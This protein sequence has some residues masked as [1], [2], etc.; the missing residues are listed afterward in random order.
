[1]KV[2]LISTE[3]EIQDGTHCDE[4]GVWFEQDGVMVIV[5]ETLDE[6]SGRIV[7]NVKLFC[8][9]VCSDTWRRAHQPVQ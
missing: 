3:G 6:E 7:P 4:C 2:V 5:G 8:G 9:H 1:M